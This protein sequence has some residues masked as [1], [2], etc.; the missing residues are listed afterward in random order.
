MA[1]APIS[2]SDI[3][4]LDQLFRT[5]FLE[6]APLY[7]LA[8]K[9]KLPFEDLKSTTTLYRGSLTEETRTVEQISDYQILNHEQ[10]SDLN[11]V[12][13]ITKE[14][15]NKAG[16][17]I[18]GLIRLENGKRRDGVDVRDTRATYVTEIFEHADGRRNLNFMLVTNNPVMDPAA[19][20]SG[21]IA[22]R[23]YFAVARLKPEYKPS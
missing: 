2:N 20:T 11:K 5:T 3:A 4:E 7:R 16:V 18:D 12:T 6:S 14:L 15:A 1:Q 23:F 19:L 13:E 9:V 22:Y 21:W 17:F 10:I 8:Y